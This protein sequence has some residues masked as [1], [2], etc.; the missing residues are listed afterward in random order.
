M[1]IMIPLIGPKQEN[2]RRKRN[3]CLTFLPQLKHQQFLEDV[4]D[5]TA[6]ALKTGTSVPIRNNS[7]GNR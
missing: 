1:Q 6:Q 5:A 4:D 2:Q 3:R 7:T